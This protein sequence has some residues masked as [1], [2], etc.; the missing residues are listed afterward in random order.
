MLPPCKDCP[1]RAPGCHGKCE[2]YAE[3][4]SWNEEH[5]EKR[6]LEGIAPEGWK[7][8]VQDMMRKRRR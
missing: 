6:H 2:K 3:F 7:K 5:R 4:V 1:A 8:V